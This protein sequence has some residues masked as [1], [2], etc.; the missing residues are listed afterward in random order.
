MAESGQTF[1][2]IGLDTRGKRVNG[3]L[4]AA[5]MK[6]AQ[7]EL[8]K[9]GIEVISLQPGTQL[10][11]LSLSL[12]TKR[13][14]KITQRDILLFTRYL[15][16]M[17]AAGLPIMQALDIVA[18]DQDNATMQALVMG[19]KNDISSGK[20]LA[21]S[22]KKYPQHFNDL[23]ISLISAG[24]KSG[25][26][27][28]I[29][30]RLG[31]YM[32]RT[33]TLKKKLKKALIYP[34]AILSVAL[35]VSLV[36]L[37]FVVPQFQSMFKSFGA[38]LPAFTRGVVAL[39]DFIRGWWWMFIIVLVAAVVGLRYLI[40]SS[41]RVQYVLDRFKLRLYIIGP[42]T[43]K[44]IIARFARTMSTTMEAGMPIVESM[45]T[46]APV[47]GNKLYTDAV[48]QICADLSS[49]H[50]LSIS[51]ASTKLFPNMAVQMI[52]VGEA[53]GSLATMLNKVADYYEEEVSHTVDN[54]SSLLEPLIMLVLG[55][56]VGSFVV[57][58]YLPIFKMGS[59]FT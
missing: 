33:E 6:D 5:D 14:K 1:Q 52:A 55:V 39:S 27:E 49:G 4:Q 35:I 42:V 37:I 19:I 53:S 12:N 58:M 28:K 40:R 30:N 56:L 50:Q 23:Y 22:F 45:K 32:E 2:W 47:M 20:T 51:M 24:E 41:P 9:R 13:K 18:H 38:Q 43:Q 11:I 15:S 10:K 54:M 7:S 59:L 57:A 26:L 8:K 29:L 46:M 34:I 16:T 25:T 17:I 31:D 21:E 48:M 44:G 36:L 3:T